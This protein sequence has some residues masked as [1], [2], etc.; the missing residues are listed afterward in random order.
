MNSGGE[1]R[2][3]PTGARSTDQA[4][5]IWLTN[6]LEEK[7]DLALEHGAVLRVGEFVVQVVLQGLEIDV[8]F[9]PAARPVSPVVVAGM[10]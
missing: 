6:D 7:F 3:R 8:E 5:R 2:V 9:L 1:E 10:V 4:K